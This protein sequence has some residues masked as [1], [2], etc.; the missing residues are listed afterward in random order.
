MYSSLGA[1][2][3]DRALQFQRQPNSNTANNQLNMTLR[4]REQNCD[5]PLPAFRECASSTDQV[6]GA[7]RR[8]GFVPALG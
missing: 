2:V 6:T 7:E 5:A 3:V 1:P 4:A 8:C